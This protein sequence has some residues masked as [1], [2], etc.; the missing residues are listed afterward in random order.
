MARLLLL[1]FL[2]S[3]PFRVLADYDKFYFSSNA[4]NWQCDGI[5]FQCPAPQVC[6]H[7]SLLDKYYCCGPGKDSVCWSG[8]QDCGGSNGAPS[9]NQVGCGSGV[10]AFC[11][12][13][14][15]EECT[16]RFNQIN[17]CWATPPTPFA[18][19]TDKEVNKTFSS[20]SSARPKASSYT[21]DLAQLIASTT[22]SSS[23]TATPSVPSSAFPSTT[24]AP[25][26]STPTQ[27][28][29]SNSGLSGG[30]IGGIVVGVIGGLALIGAGCFFFFWRRQGKSSHNELDGNPY[31]GNG[32]VQGS[33][34][35]PGQNE[36]YALH[37]AP[38]PPPTQH[39][40]EMDA[41]QQH[42][43]EMAGNNP[44]NVA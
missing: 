7:E 23:S 26:S 14:T 20:L 4:T 40:V 39:P 29:S 12:L 27:S 10:N 42:P 36:K 19:L 3:L 15:R 32:N 16:Q 8:A 25:A 41:T 11:C 28:Q 33:Y 2:L 31:T 17:I 13:N 22:S 37:E 18:N 9:S 1:S 30:A 38:Q 34:G 21:F 44:P 43:V 35:Q 24:S 5:S 6:A